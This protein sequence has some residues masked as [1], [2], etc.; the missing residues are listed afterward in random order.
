MAA[1]DREV[2]HRGAP[3]IPTPRIRPTCIQGAGCLQGYRTHKKTLPPRT[4]KQGSILGG[5]AFSCQQGT[6]VT[7]EQDFRANELGEPGLCFA[8]KLTDMYCTP[9]MST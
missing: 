7:L 2:Q 6:P 5:G 4:L 9:N 1:L 3:V 8:P